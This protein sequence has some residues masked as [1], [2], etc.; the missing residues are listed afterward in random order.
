MLTL[1][2]LN[3]TVGSC[4][5]SL[6]VNESVTVSPS[7]A[8]DV[9]L[10]V[11]FDAIVTVVNVGFSSSTLFTVNVKLFSNVPLFVSVALIFIV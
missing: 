8:N 1:L 11:L 9:S 3:A 10:A 2:D 5:A 6:A 4:I 7:F